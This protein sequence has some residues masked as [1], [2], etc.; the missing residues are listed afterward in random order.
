M[1]L[2]KCIFNATFSAAEQCCNGFSAMSG[3]LPF[4]H[5]DS[6]SQT[7]IACGID[8]VAATLGLVVKSMLLESCRDCEIF[9]IVLSAIPGDVQPERCFRNALGMSTEF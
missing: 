6:F 9:Y 3:T 5:I 8:C 7:N 1:V 2:L 4:Q